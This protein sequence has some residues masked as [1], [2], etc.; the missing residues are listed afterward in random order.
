MKNT[1]KLLTMF[2]LIAVIGFSMTTCDDGNGGGEELT[3]SSFM[4][5]S[6]LYDDSYGIIP[7]AKGYWYYFKNESSYKVTVSMNGESFTLGTL[8]YNDFFS[9]CNAANSAR[10]TMK[11]PINK[12][13]WNYDNRSRVTFTNKSG[14]GGG[15]GGGGSGD[16]TSCN[17]TGKC[18]YD[19]WLAGS[20]MRTCG[21]CNGSGYNYRGNPCGGCDGFG[22]NWDEICSR[23]GKCNVC[24]GTGKYSGRTVSSYIGT[25]ESVNLRRR[26]IK[27]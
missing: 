23:T 4:M 24:G 25:S 15:G 18:P 21:A 7:Q 10:A 22:W 6:D 3:E 26:I 19:T 9:F 20:G 1:L 11:Y 8:D 2:A 27:E 12:V 5:N 16:C 17:G 14:N 13:D